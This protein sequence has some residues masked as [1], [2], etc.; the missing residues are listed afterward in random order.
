MLKQQE[1]RLETMSCARKTA[2]NCTFNV[3]KGLGTDGEASE[4]PIH[5]SVPILGP[6]G[7]GGMTS[8][9]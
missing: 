2:K 7:G 1:S 4:A 6:R 9:P 5:K 3:P 8:D